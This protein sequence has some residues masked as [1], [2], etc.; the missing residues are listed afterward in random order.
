MQRHSLSLGGGEWW[1][2][3]VHVPATASVLN[4][5]L[6]DSALVQWD[7]NSWT[8]FC[9]GVEEALDANALELELVK[10]LEVSRFSSSQF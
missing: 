3:D 9:T 7:N 5:V 8:D 10:A 1:A 4:F 6:S 2:A